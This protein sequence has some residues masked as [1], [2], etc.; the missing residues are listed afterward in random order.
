MS[1]IYPRS[2]MISDQQLNKLLEEMKTA[3]PLTLNELIPAAQLNA[4]AN[5]G[6]P[7]PGVAA[8][9]GTIAGV[10]QPHWY[11]LEHN[12]AAAAEF[13]FR[14]L[15]RRP[16]ALPTEELLVHVFATNSSGELLTSHGGPLG[17]SVA[18][19][20]T[21]ASLGISRRAFLGAGSFPTYYFR[22]MLIGN[23][24][25]PA[26]PYLLLAYKVTT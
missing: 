24:T 15:Y 23:G 21:G 26:N 10:G 3:N 2:Q 12:Q 19:G 8:V 17:S 7:P 25:P 1:V 13:E 16:S 18:H 4:V 20:R 14:T 11:K 5:G 6:A 22:I 9:T